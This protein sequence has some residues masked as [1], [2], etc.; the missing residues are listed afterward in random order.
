MRAGDVY[1]LMVEYYYSKNNFE[2]AYNLTERMSED[3]IVL[4]PYLDKSMLQQIYNEMGVTDKHLSEND[5]DDQVSEDIVDEVDDDINDD[6]V[7][8]VE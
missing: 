5:N 7:Q 3:G 1:A 8:D 6:E 2:Q 4:G